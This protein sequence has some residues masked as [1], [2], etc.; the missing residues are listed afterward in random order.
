MR[1]SQERYRIDHTLIGTSRLNSEARGRKLLGRGY[2]ST[3]WGSD[4]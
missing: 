1:A 2:C 3:S 4:R